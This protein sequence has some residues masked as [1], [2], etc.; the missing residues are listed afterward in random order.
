MNVNLP[1]AADGNT[2][3]AD[4]HVAQW[5]A[6]AH[7]QEEADA[8]MKLSRELRET[9]YSNVIT[10][11][12]A[13]EQVATFN[14][15][16]AASYPSRSVDSL[17][18]ALAAKAEHRVGAYDDWTEFYHSWVNSQHLTDLQVNLQNA[19]DRKVVWSGRTQ[20]VGATYTLVYLLTVQHL[21]SEEL[22]WKSRK[23]IKPANRVLSILGLAPLAGVFTR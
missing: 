17:L 9:L 23:L 2:P 1:L 7:G 5:I 3:P 10:Y 19:V 4:E 11:G 8:A 13:A 16:V 21:W 20:A 15:A 12:P 14:D 18:G 22:A 6:I